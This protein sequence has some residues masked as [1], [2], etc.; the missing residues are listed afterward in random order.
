VVPLA[1]G[2]V[3]RDKKPKNH[4]FEKDKGVWG[5][6]N[7]GTGKHE[8]KDHPG[9]RNERIN[10]IFYQIQKTLT[11]HRCNQKKNKKT[12]KESRKKMRNGNEEKG[13]VQR[14]QV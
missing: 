2:Q 10:E 14:R 4:K 11:R 6:K 7:G 13:S 3:K 5:K 9:G 8:G 12:M 1:A